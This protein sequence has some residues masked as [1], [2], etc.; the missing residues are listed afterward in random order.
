MCRVVQCGVG[1]CAEVEVSVKGM[2]LKGK[3]WT[4]GMEGGGVQ[5]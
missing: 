1:R 4:V 5:C 2:G 3:D